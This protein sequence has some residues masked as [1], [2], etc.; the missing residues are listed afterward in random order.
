MNIHA[1][2]GF[3]IE[4]IDARLE[5]LC[6]KCMLGAPSNTIDQNSHTCPAEHSIR[7]NKEQIS[8]S[9]QGLVHA[10]A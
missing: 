1:Q 6:A 3:E 5:F 9:M 2:N 4:S 10:H 8:C 7:T